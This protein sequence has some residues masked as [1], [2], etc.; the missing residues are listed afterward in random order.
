MKSLPC[1]RSFPLQWWVAAMAVVLSGAAACSD[2]DDSGGNTNNQNGNWYEPYQVMPSSAL[3][4]IRDWVV[5]RGIVHCHSP[6]SHDACDGNPRPDGERNEA[7]FQDVR[8]GM[9]STRQ[10]FVFLTDHD[11]LFADFE[12]PEVLLFAPGDTLIERGGGPVA[13]RVDC[14]DGHQVVVA[15]GTESG[16]MP[17]G[18]ERHLGATPAER[19]E[20][21]NI[22]DATA[23]AALQ[24]VG[25]LVFLHHTEEWSETDVLTL[26]IDGI[27]IYNMHRNMMDNLSK[28][29]EL[30]ILLATDPESMPVP[31]LG[32]L[33]V[34]EEIPEDLAH[35]SR[36]SAI[37]RMPG[38]LA[39][40]AHQNVVDEPMEDGDRLDSFRRGMRWFSN[41]L[42][43]PPG[44]V[45]D[46]VL[47][48]VIAEG[49]LYGAFDYLG[50]PL[51]FDF[52]GVA[53]G[54]VVEMGGETTGAASVTL[55]VSAPVVWNLDPSGP[56]PTIRCLL[57]R[58]DGAGA[59]EEVDSAEGALSYV[60]DPGVYRAEVRILP[61]HLRPWLGPTP[62]VWVVEKVWI[63]SNPIYVR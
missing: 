26:P 20:A 46:A 55:S 22:I 59:W 53:D 52:H 54:Q 19:Y 11:D 47:K 7:C 1:R 4:G 50:Y 45:D 39:T 10:D 43:V 14:G 34:F 62:D 38:V 2:D 41:Y 16:M 15:A 51:G 25:A 6:Y 31:E 58:A 29:I 49:R 56:Q 3:P 42:L 5:R 35:W 36:A 9:C 37:R 61:D 17:I 63:Y 32:L 44:P 30:A 33:G 28:V 18:I 60:A 24:G 57:L 12:F 40:D 23:I 8:H 27:E 13:N 21:Y 48:A